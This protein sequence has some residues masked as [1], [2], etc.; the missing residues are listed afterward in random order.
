MLYP[1]ASTGTAPAAPSLFPDLARFFAPKS[2][3]LV[4][5]TEDL[6]KFGGR[7]LS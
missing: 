1:A 6:S 2:V 7:C 4:G 3:A 5:A